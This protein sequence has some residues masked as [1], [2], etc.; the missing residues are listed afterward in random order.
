MTFAK[1]ARF[2]HACDLQGVRLWVSVRFN[3]HMLQ[4]SDVRATTYTAAVQS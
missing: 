4:T 2:L 1:T 3:L